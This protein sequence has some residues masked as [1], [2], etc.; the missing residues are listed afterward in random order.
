MLIDFIGHSDG[1]ALHT[2]AQQKLID[3]KKFSRLHK[4]SKR[5][6]GPA[7]FIR[8]WFYNLV[9]SKHWEGLLSQVVPRGPTGPLGTPSRTPWTLSRQEQRHRKRA[10][11]SDRTFG[12]DVRPTAAHRVITPRYWDNLSSAFIV[13]NVAVMIRGC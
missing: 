8:S 13:F 4:P 6:T 5:E 9:E 7:N 11:T 2:D 3:L 12:W 10:R 1:T